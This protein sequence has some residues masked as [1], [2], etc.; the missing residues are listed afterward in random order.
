[1][2]AEKELTQWDSMIWLGLMSVGV[3]VR[4]WEYMMV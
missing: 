2:K 4:L 1:M 3:C